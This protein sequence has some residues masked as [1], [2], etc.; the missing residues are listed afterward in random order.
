M[1]YLPTN[2]VAM[3]L[4]FERVERI[5]SDDA[6]FQENASH[7]ESVPS[8]FTEMYE[9]IVRSWVE[10]TRGALDEVTLILD[11][12]SEKN[13]TTQG[14]SPSKRTSVPK[15]KRSKKSRPNMKTENI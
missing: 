15:T 7:S 5:V 4:H 13:K 10:R 2:E 11:R 3:L 1:R 12:L 8:K 14:N 9:H 6:D